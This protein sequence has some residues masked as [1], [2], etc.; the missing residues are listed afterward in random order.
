M[1]FTAR[2]LFAFVVAGALASSPASAQAPDASGRWDVQ[3]NAP[4]GAHKA[5]LTLKKAGEKVTGTIANPGGEIQVEGTQKGADVSVSFIYRGGDNPILITMTGTQKG[6]SIAGAAT[7][8]DSPGDWTGT[9]TG[10]ADSAGGSPSAPAA[11]LD[12]SGAWLFEVTSPAGSGTPTITFNQS[13]E[14]LAG[15]YVGQLGEA[16]IQGTLK[17]AELSFSFDVTVQDTKLHVVYSGT[18]TKD[19]IKGTATF[20]ELGEGTFTA[21]RK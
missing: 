4:D 18:A 19:A 20:G 12:I 3:L 14:T 17:G 2:A 7:F 10:K 5:T 1:V 16:P 21:R 13:G 11:A 6:D 15:Q 9:R 8:G